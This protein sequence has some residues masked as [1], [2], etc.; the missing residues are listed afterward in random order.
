MKTI[1]ALAILTSGSFANAATIAAKEYTYAMDGATCN[2]SLIP[3]ASGAA[4]ETALKEV[5]RACPNPKVLVARVLSV[6][7]R[8]CG[9]WDAGFEATAEIEFNCLP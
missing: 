6:E 7:P 9:T 4:L 8:G 2:I 3:E 1:L 5:Y